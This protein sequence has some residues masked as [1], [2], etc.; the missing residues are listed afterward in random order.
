MAGSTTN[1]GLT[2][3][4]YSE[5]ADIVVINTNM[6]TLDSKIGAVGSTSLQAQITSANEAISNNAVNRQDTV[7]DCNDT[8]I[9]AGCFRII[10]STVNTPASSMYG[11]LYNMFGKD[12]YTQIAI[13]IG[14]SRMF[15]RRYVNG[16]SDWVELAYSALRVSVTTPISIPSSGT[17]ATYTMVGIT[18]SHELIR[19]NFSSSAENNPPVNLT[20]TTSNGSFT[21]TNNGGTTSETIRPMFAMPTSVT[22]TAST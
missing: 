9:G 20:W 8:S 11:V 16:W 12:Y 17:S 21:I 4:T 3:P 15:F 22:A 19:W 10:A 1:L 7:A 13:M 6:D 18:S 2:K 14:N 5:D